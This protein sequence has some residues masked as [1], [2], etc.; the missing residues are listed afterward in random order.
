MGPMT[1][2]PWGSLMVKR[3]ELPADHAELKKAIQDQ[4]HSTRFSFSDDLFSKFCETAREFAN[5]GVT[6]LILTTPLHPFTNETP[7]CDPDGTS[8]EGF[9]EVVRHMEALDQA[10]PHLWFRDFHKDGS[11]DFPPGEFYDVDHLNRQGAGHL[12]VLIQEVMRQ[13][14]ADEAA[15]GA[16]SK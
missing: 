1:F 8:H 13:C 15:G 4:C 10:T 14:D 3:S 9:R 12:A 6:V 7:A 11:H 2:D 5:R 16:T